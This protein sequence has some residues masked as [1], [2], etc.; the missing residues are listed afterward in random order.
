MGA[1]HACFI[2]EVANARLTAICD[3]RKDLADKIG[4]QHGVKVFYDSKKMYDSGEIDAV[5]IA[6]PHYDHPHLTISAFN[7]GLHVLVEKPIAVHK[8]DAIRMAEAHKK[9]PKLKFSAMFQMR[10]DSFYR[11]VKSLIDGGELG[12]I[13]RVNWIITNWFR[14]QRYYDSGGWRATWKGEGGG[15][16]LN[17]CPHNLDLFQWFFGMPVKLRAFCSLGKYHNIEVE[18]DVTAYCEYK[19]GATGIFIASTGEAPGTNRLEITG[20]RG[21]LIAENGKLTFNRNEIPVCEFSKTTDKMFDA[22]ASWNIE[23]PFANDPAH[24]RKIIQNFTDAVVNDSPLLV[25]AE[26]GSNSVELANAMLMSSLKGKTVE[27]PIDTKEFE[28][29]LRKL[30]KNSK[31]N[32]KAVKEATP[33]DFTSSFNKK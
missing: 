9:H 5:I 24:H 18:D 22:P 11:K 10:T 23:I 15:V 19:N 4:E 33:A 1:A 30:V 2:K 28:G 27:L 13:M 32:K 7:T 29:I 14:S 25:K 20:D 8:A 31:F 3:I 16:L 6:T 21:R 12:R 17:Q 26:E